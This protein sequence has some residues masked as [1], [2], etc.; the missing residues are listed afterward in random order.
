MINNFLNADFLILIIRRIPCCSVVAFLSVHFNHEIF[1]REIGFHVDVEEHAVFLGWDPVLN[2]VM[3]KSS[4][5]LP[6]PCN[7]VQEFSNLAFKFSL[8]F[9]NRNFRKR[10]GSGNPSILW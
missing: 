8:P 2:R 4:M 7:A 1:G 10:A 5:S 9:R 3:V 6:G